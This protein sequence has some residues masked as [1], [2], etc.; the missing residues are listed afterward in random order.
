MKNSCLQLLRYFV[1]EISIS[2][3]PSFN[4][5]KDRDSGMEEFSV[6]TAV[7][8]QAAPEGFPGHSWLI[9]MQISQG[10]KQGKNSPYQ[11]KLVIVG[12]FAFNDGTETDE[13]EAQFVQVNGSTILYGAAREILRST[14][15]LGPWG[16]VI[17]PTI[18]FY[19]KQATHTGETVPASKAD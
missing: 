7:N 19:E 15:T 17:I 14:M 1:P 18:S 2:A 8:R 9:E 16:H 4:P 3:N 10:I 11:F 13:K 12:M 6:G 5:D